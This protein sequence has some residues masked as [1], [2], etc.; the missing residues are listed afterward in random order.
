MWV[1]ICRV[2]LGVG[3]KAQSVLVDTQ[4]YNTTLETPLG[5]RIL[6]QLMFV[7]VVIWD[8]WKDPIDMDP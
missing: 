8:I 2:M 3:T 1:A 7:G 5:W 6:A 4:T